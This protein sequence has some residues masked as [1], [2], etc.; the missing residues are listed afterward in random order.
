VNINWQFFRFPFNDERWMS[1]AIIGGLLGLFGI[2]IWPLLLPLIGYAMRI[3]RQTSE[4]NS[5]SL[6]AWTGW[7]GLFRDGLRFVV[8]WLLYSLPGPLLSVCAALLLLYAPELMRNTTLP[9]EFQAIGILAYLALIGVGTILSLPLFFLTLV[10]GTRMIVH[11]SLRSAFEFGNILRLARAGI[12][13]FLLSFAIF[14]G[15]WFLVN[16]LAYLL[17]FTII[18][19]CLVPLLI[20]FSAFYVPVMMGAL[21]G[22]AYYETQS[23]LAVAGELVA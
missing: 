4:G 12:G 13:N 5:P 22:T 6:P 1:K 14:Y 15:T 17:F 19:A 20:G 18:L 16:S 3:L 9:S 21:F 10:A 23:E 11:D 8:V 2:I 7:G